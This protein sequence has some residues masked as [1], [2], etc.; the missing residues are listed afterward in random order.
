MPHTPSPHFD[1]C[2]V[3]FCYLLSPL[4]RTICSHIAFLPS[5]L[6]LTPFSLFV[7]IPNTWATSST[8]TTCP[9]SSPCSPTKHCSPTH[10]LS[11]LL[12]RV[13]LLCILA[14]S[15]TPCTPRTACRSGECG[16]TSTIL[17]TESIFSNRTV[18]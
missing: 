12:Q 13:F 10:S 14:L 16:G 11:S 3:A 15:R 2:S 9:V 8:I 18:L 17:A 1:P 4:I 7:G 6:S 5:C